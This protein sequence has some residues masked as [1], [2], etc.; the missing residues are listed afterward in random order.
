MTVAWLLNAASGPCGY[1]LTMSGRPAVQMVNY[2]AALILNVVLNVVLIQR[3]GMTGAAMA[4]AT[5]ILV[6]TVARVVQV[7]TFARMLPFS[8]DLLKGFCAAIVAGAGGLA[9]SE[10]I[11]GELRSL[12]VGVAVVGITYLVCIRLLGLEEDDRLV[13]DALRQRFRIR[14]AWM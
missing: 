2:I 5:T 10:L 7:W 6:L 8:R 4:W 14:K 12:F 3:F 13:L 11:A 1:V 9:T